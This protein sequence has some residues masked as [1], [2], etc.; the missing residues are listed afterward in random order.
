MSDRNMEVVSGR[1]TPVL[2]RALLA[3]TLE[4]NL[5]Y[6]GLVLAAPSAGF[7]AEALPQKVMDALAATGA[8]ARTALAS[9]P[10]T[11]FSLAFD[12]TRFWSAALEGLPDESLELTERY[13]AASASPMHSA[14]CEVALFFAWHV[15]RT[16]GLWSAAK[17]Q[18]KG[19]NTRIAA[20]SAHNSN[21]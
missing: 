18:T 6:V 15:Y 10:Y 3:R 8:A 19:K 21:G 1:C 13:G 4:L 5:D 16:D 12:D 7:Q 20:R 17:C 11:L 9:C 14:F 2:S